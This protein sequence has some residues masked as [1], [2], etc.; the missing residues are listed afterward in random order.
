MLS[1]RALAG[2]KVQEHENYSHVDGDE[3]VAQGVD[4]EG[5]DVA[6]ASSVTVRARDIDFGDRELGKGVDGNDVEED[7]DMVDDFDDD[8][9][10][11]T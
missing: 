11:S 5:D 3:R 4:D 6:S 10:A 9:Y 2:R 8:G 1:L 7:L